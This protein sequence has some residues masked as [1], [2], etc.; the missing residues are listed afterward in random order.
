[1][2]AGACHG[3]GTGHPGVQA[4]GKLLLC[5]N[6]GSAADCQHLAAEFTSRLRLDFARPALP[7][8][9]LT[10]D[11]SFL[12]AFANDFSFTGAFARAV[13][14]LGRP[15]DVLLGIT[16]SG[17]SQNVLAAFE[18]ARRQNL[19]CIAFTGQAGVPSGA[20]VDVAIAVPSAKT[21][22]VQE[23]HIALA[24]LLCQIVEESL[25]STSLSP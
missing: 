13:E 18:Q 9:A 4:G 25:F 1:V 8:L 2:R 3:C 5:G 23:T 10:T 16:T 15:G 22:H 12:T 14:V 21:Q 20:A 6:G 19:K 24:H 7:A 17:R 11:A